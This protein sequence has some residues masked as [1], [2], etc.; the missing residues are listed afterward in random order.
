M[1]FMWE[2][3]D[4]QTQKVLF[5]FKWK[6]WMSAYFLDGGAY[7]HEKEVLLHDGA[8]VIVESIEEV[9][10]DEGKVLYTLITLKTDKAE[11]LL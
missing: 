10:D 7:D 11:W 1:S 9:K 6:D 2:N 5:H 8:K 4:S 3:Q